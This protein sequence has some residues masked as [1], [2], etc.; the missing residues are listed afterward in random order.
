M[1]TRFVRLNLDLVLDFE[2]PMEEIPDVKKIW[3]AI[4]DGMLQSR[5]LYELGAKA[6]EPG[7]LIRGRLD[8]RSREKRKGKAK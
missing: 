6:V 8:F 4:K 2:T 7:A 5:Q 1:K 3:R